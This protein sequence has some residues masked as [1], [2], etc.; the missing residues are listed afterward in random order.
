MKRY[1]GYL[2]AI[3]FLAIY[4]TAWFTGA[5]ME[6]ALVLI[7]LG[8]LLFAGILLHKGIFW[9]GVF[10]ALPALHMIYRG[11]DRKSVV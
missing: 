8:C 2:P 6:L 11:G 9:G 4:L 7:W 1:L 5:S 3:L 10:G